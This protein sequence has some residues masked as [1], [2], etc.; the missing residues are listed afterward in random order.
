MARTPVD[1]VKCRILV[2][3]PAPHPVCLNLKES[4]ILILGSY[5]YCQNAVLIFRFLSKNN[6]EF[7]K[8]IL[9]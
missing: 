1:L 4:L 5:F 2:I 6:V 8:R 9:H 7:I 3:P